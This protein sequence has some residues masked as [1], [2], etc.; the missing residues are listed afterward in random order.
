LAG[1]ANLLRR[2]EANER[3]QLGEIW[4]QKGAV[5]QAFSRKHRETTLDWLRRLSPGMENVEALPGDLPSAPLLSSD[6][7]FR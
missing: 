7:Q 2:N 6:A 5:F 4:Q 3:S 1:A